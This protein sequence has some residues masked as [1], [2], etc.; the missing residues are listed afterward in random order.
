MRLF[1]CFRWQAIYQIFWRHF[2]TEP[3]LTNLPETHSLEKAVLQLYTTVLRQ[4]FDI[5]QFY[6]LYSATLPKSWPIPAKFEHYNPYILFRPPSYNCWMSWNGQR[7]TNTRIFSLPCRPF[8]PMHALYALRGEGT[9]L[10]WCLPQP[11]SIQWQPQTTNNKKT[12]SKH[13]R[14]DFLSS[15]TK[16]GPTISKRI[17]IIIYSTQT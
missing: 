17:V 5:L 4:T 2:H 11:R 10:G 6:F 14:T 7:S 9:G 8:T 1:R 13:Q 16:V 15:K 3:T 12:T